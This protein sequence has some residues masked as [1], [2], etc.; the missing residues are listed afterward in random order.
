MIMTVYLK[1]TSTWKV[2][3]HVEAL[4]CKTNVP[5]LLVSRTC[6]GADREVEPVRWKA[7]R[8]RHSRAYAGA[9]CSKVRIN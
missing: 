1:G 7:L 9:I 3:D 6:P 2:D 4:G 5:K 8:I